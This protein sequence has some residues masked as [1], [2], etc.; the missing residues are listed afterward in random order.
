MQIPDSLPP[1]P[2][3]DLLLI[4]VF[5]FL[6]V[7]TLLAVLAGV[8]HVLTRLFPERP[9]PGAGAGPAGGGPDAAVVAAISAAAAAAYPGLVVRHIEERR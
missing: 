9:K 5:A 4:S 7:F 1:T 2:A 6:A 8:M 3:P